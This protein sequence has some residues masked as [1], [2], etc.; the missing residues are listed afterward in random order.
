MNP[1]VVF[2]DFSGGDWGI[3]NP[4]K[5]S[6][7]QWQGLNV[8]VYPDGSIGP[9]NPIVQLA[10]TGLPT[11]STVRPS[12]HFARDGR[13]F[14][15]VGATV[16]YQTTLSA[17]SVT[18]CTGTL[19]GGSSSSAAQLY[20]DLRLGRYWINRV[21]LGLDY[22]NSSNACNAVTT[23]V[24]FRMIAVKGD[25]M[26]GVNG[27]VIY[28]SAAGDYTSWPALNQIDLGEGSDIQWVFTSGDT[29]YVA[30]E[31]S[32]YAVQGV[33]GSTTTVRQIAASG[34]PN[35]RSPNA[36]T[37]AKSMNQEPWRAAKLADDTVCWM[38]AENPSPRLPSLVNASQNSPITNAS[39]VME[40]SWFKGGQIRSTKHPN[41]SRTSVALSQSYELFHAA[42]KDSLILFPQGGRITD[43]SAGEFL[44]VRPDGYQE[45]HEFLV[46]SGNAYGGASVDLEFIPAPNTAWD[47]A[48]VMD[49]GVVAWATRDAGTNA[50]KFFYWL[51]DPGL[52]V[53]PAILDATN[54]GFNFNC[55][56]ALAPWYTTDG[57]V[58]RVRGVDVH[59]TSYD[60]TVSGASF[61]VDCEVIGV[62]NSNDV[63]SFNAS[64]QDSSQT[65]QVQ[66][67]STNGPPARFIKRVRFGN[68]SFGSGFY[69]KFDLKRVSISRVV[70]Y[71]ESKAAPVV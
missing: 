15:I 36:V 19:T 26:I 59:C 64:F 24:A 52:P 69:L 22:V 25:R 68:S 4:L 42:V 40:V 17:T 34:A 31:A 66:S 60:E 13:V 62:D 16:Y 1:T 53:N 32:L 28:F 63:D 23:P 30:T 8:Q 2:D 54:S 5:V 35:L 70:V 39:G 29:L 7:N 18:T 55:N 9:R 12:I 14:Y 58:A 10:P 6:K 46:S 71:V 56:L 21:G 33:L 48:A 51:A 38:S 41:Y 20:T 45:R 27:R 37:G 11:T 67:P 65:V 49:G 3:S 44:L 57:T 50:I 43:T 61:T 47:R